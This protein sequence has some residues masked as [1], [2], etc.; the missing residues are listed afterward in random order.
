MALLLLVV[1]Y[2]CTFPFVYEHCKQ[3]FP[4]LNISPFHLNYLCIYSVTQLGLLSFSL[5]QRLY[6]LKLEFLFVSANLI[7]LIECS[8]VISRLFGSA[9]LIG[10]IECSPVISRLCVSANLIGLIECSPVISILFGSVNL[11]GLIECSPVISLLFG[12]VNLIGLIECSPV[13]SLW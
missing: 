8:P 9:N 4:V 10:L 6:R 11:I 5:F 12:S 13:I 2:L 7:G 3:L 1:S